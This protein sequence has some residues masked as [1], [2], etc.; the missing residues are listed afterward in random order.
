MFGPFLFDS[1]HP[2]TLGAGSSLAVYMFSHES[3]V[4]F[5]ISL[6]LFVSLFLPPLQTDTKGPRVAAR[7]GRLNRLCMCPS[8]LPAS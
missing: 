7:K 3:V 1:A 6:Y 4:T 2:R 8:V 5:V